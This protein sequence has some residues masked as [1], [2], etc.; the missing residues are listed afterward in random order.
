M[1]NYATTIADSIRLD[2]PQIRVGDRMLSPQ[3][4]R[5]YF[6]GLSEQY[7]NIYNSYGL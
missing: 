6:Q 7:R 5:E 4:A 3:A 1:K 2:G